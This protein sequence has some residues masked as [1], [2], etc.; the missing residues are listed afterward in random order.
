MEGGIEAAVAEVAAVA[1]LFDFIIL[2][3]LHTRDTLPCRDSARELQPKEK[4]KKNRFIS[5]NTIDVFQLIIFKIRYS[6]VAWNNSA[7]QRDVMT[8]GTCNGDP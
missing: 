1:A 8:L 5:C 7:E 3:H 2:A 6:D 4:K